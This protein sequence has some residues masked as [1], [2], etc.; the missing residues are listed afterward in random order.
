M[1]IVRKAIEQDFEK[2]YPLFVK[3]QNPKLSKDDWRQL[4]VDHWQCKEGYFGYVL[5]NQG[6]VVGFLGL[7]FSNRTLNGRKTKFC[8]LTSWVVEENFRNQSLSL[9]LPVLKL[10]E[11][12]LTI[13]TPSKET[14]LVAQ[15][16]GFQDLESKL[17]IIFPFPSFFTGF[18][19]CEISFDKSLSSKTLTGEVLQIYKDHAFLNCTHVHIHTSSGECYLMG[20]KIY[21]KKLPFFQI[22]YISHP[23]IFSKFSG[24]ISMKISLKLKTVSIIIEERFLKGNSI[25]FA[26]SWPL[27]HP[28]LYKAKSLGKSDIDSLYSELPILNL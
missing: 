26:K 17:Q 5:E 19:L 1:A 4:F 15:K 8:N 16:L 12:A 10:N 25:F 28:R 20:A 24:K 7:I 18:S 6:E 27:P 9:L 13:F 3:F 11:Y 23:E 21:R 14:Y 2:I 22:Y